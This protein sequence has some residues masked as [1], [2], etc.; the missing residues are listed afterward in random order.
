MCYYF[1]E[2]AANVLSFL[3]SCVARTHISENKTIPT[4]HLQKYK[5]ER[6]P[7]PQSIIGVSAIE[8]WKK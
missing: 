2:V 6:Q 5:T 7:Q 8:R 1:L 4:I 3:N